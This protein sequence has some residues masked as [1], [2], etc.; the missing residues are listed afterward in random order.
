MRVL[1]LIST[2]DALL[3]AG[4]SAA[5]GSSFP[6]G[7]TLS[8][9]SV[10]CKTRAI[11][12]SGRDST[13]IE[14]TSMA[15]SD[16]LLNDDEMGWDSESRRLRTTPPVAKS[17]ARARFLRALELCIHQNIRHLF[18]SCCAGGNFACNSER[19]F[20]PPKHLTM[21]QLQLDLPVPTP[22]RRLLL[23]NPS[24]S[25][26]TSC[27]CDWEAFLLQQCARQCCSSQKPRCVFSHAWKRTHGTR[28]ERKTTRGREA[29]KRDRWRKKT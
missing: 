28:D 1:R 9:T 4:S 6:S 5:N 15:S 21:R 29:R 20:Q 18:S 17:T 23:L 24:L 27:A 19:H 10:Q 22:F 25:A 8:A 2:S 26:L 7:S 3:I 13:T 14:G 12:G 16:D 11:G